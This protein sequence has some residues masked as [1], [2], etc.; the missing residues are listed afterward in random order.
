MKWAKILMPIVLAVA[1]VYS[2]LLFTGPRMKD[3]Q[4]NIRAYRAAMPLPPKGALP[5]T[6]PTAPIP[7][8]EQAATMT[9]DLPATE[10]NIAAGHACYEYYCLACHGQT[11]DGRGPV[12]ESFVPSP[13]DLRSDSVRK[14][15]D[16]QLIRA[17]LTGPGH[18]PVLTNIGPE[19]VLQYTVLPA[20]RPYLVLYVRSLGG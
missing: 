11:G 20:H 14:M 7:T 8:E 9:I 1:G 6:D 19:A 15:T 18:R 17:M 10:Q 12:G 2:Y 5:T 16:G 13:G 4:P 3:T